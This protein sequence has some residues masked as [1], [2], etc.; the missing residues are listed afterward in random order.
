[1]LKDFETERSFPFSGTET[2]SSELF[3]RRDPK[4]PTEPGG[5]RAYLTKAIAVDAIL[6]VVSL[7]PAVPPI[8]LD[9]DL[10]GTHIMNEL[11]IF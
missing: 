2:R 5:R 1:M 6:G 9:L 10:T 7:H 11:V 3:H 8:H 4:E